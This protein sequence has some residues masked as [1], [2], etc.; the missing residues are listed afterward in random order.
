MTHAI[1]LVEELVRNA[2]SVYVTSAF[3]TA[4]LLHTIVQHAD[5]SI[6]TDINSDDVRGFFCVPD[7]AKI[8]QYFSQI[9]LLVYTVK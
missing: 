8:S 2:C 9:F 5:V 6:P 3:K 1:Y 7:F 4:G